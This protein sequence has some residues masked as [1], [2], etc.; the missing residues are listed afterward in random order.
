M[1]LRADEWQHDL[2]Q[3]GEHK[4][5]ELVNNNDHFTRINAEWR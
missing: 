4:P 1:R 2:Y 3:S 5:N